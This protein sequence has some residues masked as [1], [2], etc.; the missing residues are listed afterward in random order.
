MCGQLYVDTHITPG[1][2]L[3]SNAGTVA[4]AA[5]MQQMA[6]SVGCHGVKLAVLEENL[7]HVRC[8]ASVSISGWTC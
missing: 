5:A 3:E 4:L 6:D 7:C 2:T 1:V 8:F